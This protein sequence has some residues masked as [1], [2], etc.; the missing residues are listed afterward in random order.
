MCLSS[1]NH[2]KCRRE[3]RARARGWQKR[4]LNMKKGNRNYR[5]TRCV[6]RP[7]THLTRKKSENATKRNKK[8]ERIEKYICIHSSFKAIFL[9]ERVHIQ[10]S[11]YFAAVE[12]QKNIS[13]KSPHCVSCCFCLSSRAHQ[14]NWERSRCNFFNIYQSNPPAGGWE[15]TARA[16]FITLPCRQQLP[17]QLC[18]SRNS[19]LPYKRSE[20][21]TFWT[22]IMKIY[23][24]FLK[25]LDQIITLF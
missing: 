24:T 8:K 25:F 3:A 21:H 7:H 14:L 9:R 18:C 1:C 6:A 16:L 17:T 10:R 5:P 20:H 12:A 22:W 4:S 13:K 15:N 23:C 11:T 2:C 19:S